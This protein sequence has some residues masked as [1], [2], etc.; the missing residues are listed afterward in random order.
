VAVAAFIA[1]AV[2]GGRVGNAACHG[3]GPIIPPIPF[4]WH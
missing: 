2:V 4:F 1:R 3:D